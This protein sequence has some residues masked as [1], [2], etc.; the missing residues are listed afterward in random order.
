MRVP[1]LTDRCPLGSNPE[2]LKKPPGQR[3]QPPAMPETLVELLEVTC[4]HAVLSR[5]S[6]FLYSFPFL[7]LK[8]TGFGPAWLKSTARWLKTNSL[9]SPKCHSLPPQRLKK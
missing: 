2:G 5:N 9:E 1:E 8:A 3:V 4:T 7:I 6:H